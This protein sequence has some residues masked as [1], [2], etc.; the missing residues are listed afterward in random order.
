M[1]VTAYQEKQKNTDTK[2]GK[3]REGENRRPILG[4]LCAALLQSFR[5][6]HSEIDE[7]KGLR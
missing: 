4:K 3:R 6:Q 5:E 1:N 2:T 7:G